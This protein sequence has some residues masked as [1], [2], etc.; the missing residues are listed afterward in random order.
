LFLRLRFSPVARDQLLNQP[1]DSD[2][3]AAVLAQKTIHV[4]PDR[5]AAPFSVTLGGARAVRSPSPEAFLDAVRMSGSG[6]AFHAITGGNGVARVATTLYLPKGRIAN[7]IWISLYRH[8]ARGW[9]P[10]AVPS[11]PVLHRLL[12]EPN[13]M[14]AVNR[15]YGPD[16][17]LKILRLDLTMERIRVDLNARES[18]SHENVD[19]P[20]DHG[21]LD[22]SYLPLLERYKR[23]DS[24]AVKYTAEFESARLTKQPSLDPW[25]AALSQQSGTPIQTLAVRV[26]EDYLPTR[27]RTD[28]RQSAGTER[29][30]LVTAARKPEAVDPRLVPAQLPRP[31]NISDVRQWSRFALVDVRFLSTGYSMLFERRGG[32]WVFLCVVSPYLE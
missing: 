17:P 30:Q 9:A 4:H 18:L 8:D 1:I 26:L 31:E 3:R 10:L 32:R 23:S 13:L 20:I 5:I 21:A 19:S 11:H 25:I 12:N 2:I 14:P 24:P 22:A 7:Q 28:G 29:A 15:N 27:F 6:V 16:H